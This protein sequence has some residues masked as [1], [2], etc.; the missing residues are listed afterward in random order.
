[1]GEE[2]GRMELWRR[3]GWRNASMRVRLGGGGTGARGGARRDYRWPNGRP[4]PGLSWPGLFGPGLHWPDQ[5]GGPCR[6]GPRATL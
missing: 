2:A 4:G 5:I 6:A 1:M 3:G